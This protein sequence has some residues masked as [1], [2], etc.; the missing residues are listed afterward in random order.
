MLQPI[1]ADRSLQ[2]T[3]LSEVMLSG[4]QVDQLKLLLG[5]KQDHHLDESELIALAEAF[6]SQ[7]SGSPVVQG[8]VDTVTDYIEMIC[9]CIN[10]RCCAFGGAYTPVNPQVGVTGKP[11]ER[12]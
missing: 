11:D 12:R 8:S 3:A 7:R 4:E 2:D 5:L 1:S 6:L 9:G 10:M